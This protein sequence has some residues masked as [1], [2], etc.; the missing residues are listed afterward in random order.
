MPSLW[1]LK[2]LILDSEPGQT[3]SGTW[4]PPSSNQGVEA[5]LH[6]NSHDAVV[7]SRSEQQVLARHPVKSADVSQRIGTI[8]RKV[9]FPDGS[10]FETSDNDQMDDI[11]AAHTKP[12]WR[13]V[14]G[15]E[16]F[17]PRLFGLVALVGVLAYLIYRFTLPVLVEIAVVI[18]PPVVPEMMA[19][20]TLK[21]LDTTVMS[22]SSLPDE[23]K[24]KIQSGFDKLVAIAKQS[25]V[26]FR[27]NFRDGGFI[28]PNAFALPDGNV[29]LTDQLVELAS[30]DTEMLV[31]VLAHEIGHVEMKH[32]LRQM[33]TAAGTYGLIAMVTGD[34]G[35]GLQEVL[36]GG[37]GFLA[38]ANSRSDESAADLRSVELMSQA[39]YDPTA[40]ARFFAL[41]QEELGDTSETSIL[42]THPGTPERQKVI[43]DYSRKLSGN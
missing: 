25:D 32:S 30:D 21:T 8:P 38:L 28:G 16:E 10:V 22:P 4:Y 15:L 39:G 24:A 33:Y 6:V 9:A 14:H 23:T 19:A 12:F 36:T 13:M 31:G 29:I 5:G 7:I 20:G 3:I 34:L 26:T 18:T 40:I 27:L 41:L 42:S 2:G 37:A 17:H 35:G 11:L 1:I 43:L